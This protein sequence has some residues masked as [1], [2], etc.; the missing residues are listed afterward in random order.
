MDLRMAINAAMVDR[1]DQNIGRLVA[2][3]KETKR[4]GNT[5]ILHRRYAPRG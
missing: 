2:H 1:L 3:L 5:L 4:F